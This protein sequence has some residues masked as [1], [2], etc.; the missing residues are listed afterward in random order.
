VEVGDN[1]SLCLLAQNHLP[2]A[3]RT[4]VLGDAIKVMHD[5]LKPCAL[6]ESSAPAY[7]RAV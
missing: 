7:D 6:E 3:G 2:V 4:M 5:R 1:A